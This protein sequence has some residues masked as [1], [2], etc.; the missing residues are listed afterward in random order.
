MTV[1][2][3]KAKIRASKNM[4]TTMDNVLIASCGRFSIPFVEFAMSLGVFQISLIIKAFTNSISKIGII[5]ST[6]I[7]AQ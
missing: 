7:F 2:A 6:T 3:I 1:F 5:L 4:V